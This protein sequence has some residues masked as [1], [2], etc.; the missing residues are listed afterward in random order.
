M[1]PET[2]RAFHE[3]V[4]RCGRFLL[5]THINPDGD[6]LGCETAMALY[7]GARGKQVWVM[8]DAIVPANFAF[9][10]QRVAME[11]YDP[12]LAERRL[13][14]S[15]ALI[16]LDTGNPQRLGRLAQHL[17]RHD[18]EVVVIDHHASHDGFGRLNLVEPEASATSELLYELFRDEPGAITPE[19]AEALYVALMTDT[20]SF[21]FSNTDAPAHRMAAELI[22]LGVDPQ[23]IHAQVF[24][25]ASAGRLRFVGEVLSG[26]ELEADGRIVVLQAH[27]EQFER[28]G[29]VGADTEGLVDMPRSVAGVEVVVL[30][31]EV[32]AG[33]IKVSMRST[34]RV[35]VEG[36]ALRLGG[37]G[38][39]HAAGALL[40][41]QR[42]E[43]RSRV[44]AELKR[45]VAALPARGVPA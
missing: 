41:G 2:R 24:S 45:L 29:L 35:S 11:S 39:A 7:L 6:G 5:T 36:L 8:N 38:H 27:P 16:V 4:Q 23:K 40:R 3:V 18:L 34:G 12:S 14:E 33:K 19:I 26:L 1:S 30:L 10:T 20:G 42:A 17:G 15:E 32:E 31:S 43:V 9:L 13:A 25:H 22:H 21:R 28:H 44:V 37:G